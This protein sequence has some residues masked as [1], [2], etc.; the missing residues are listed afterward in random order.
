MFYSQQLGRQTPL[1]ARPWAQSPGYGSPLSHLAM[2]SLRYHLPIIQSG[3]GGSRG[4]RHLPGVSGKWAGAA[5][6]VS[7]PPSPPCATASTRVRIVKLHMLAGCSQYMALPTHRCQ[8]PGLRHGGS[9]G[10]FQ[11]PSPPQMHPASG[12]W[13]ATDHSPPRKRVPSRALSSVL[14]RVTAR[15][16]AP[17]AQATPQ[18]EGVGGLA[19]V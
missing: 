6:R 12:L 2:L 14:G 17:Q 4:P 3:K 19:T 11:G 13:E 16:E 15:Q 9:G 10:P 7:S 1:C 5:A 8:H 18:R